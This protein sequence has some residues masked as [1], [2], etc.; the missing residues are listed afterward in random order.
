MAFKMF[1]A[2]AQTVLPCKQ[3][4]L[5]AYTSGFVHSF[6][7]TLTHAHYNR[8]GYNVYINQYFHCA[9]ITYTELDM[10]PCSYFSLEY[11]FIYL[12]FSARKCERE[13]RYHKSGGEYPR[14]NT[15]DTFLLIQKRKEK[16]KRRTQAHKSLRNVVH[17]SKPLQCRAELTEISV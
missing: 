16:K 13:S 4:S 10:E 7:R 15:T 3:K 8:E 1:R 6:T 2:V 12:F 5:D 17:N 9:Y 11:L 14:V